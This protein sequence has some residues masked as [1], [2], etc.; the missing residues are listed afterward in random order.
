MTEPLTIFS[1][2]ET[3]K[4]TLLDTEKGVELRW[5]RLGGW[6]DAMGVNRNTRMW[7]QIGRET[8]DAPIHVV[9]DHLHKILRE[10]RRP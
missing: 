2:D 9:A 6:I 4:I 10:V 3:E 7:S 5:W 1:P 8:I